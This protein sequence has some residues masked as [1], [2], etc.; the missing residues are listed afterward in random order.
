MT[1]N[2][3]PLRIGIAGYGPGVARGARAL[4]LLG[5]TLVGVADRPWSE[6]PEAE[7]GVLKTAAA[8]A[9]QPYPSV[10]ALLSDVDVLVVASTLSLRRRH[11]MAAFDRGIP[12][13]CEAPSAA[14][15][16]DAF[17]MARQA[18]MSYL[19]GATCLPA[20]RLP[21]V[22]AMRE[23]TA[24]G[25]LGRVLF[26]EARL[27]RRD[28]A[29]EQEQR[30]A[31]I[32]RDED[33]RLPTSAEF[34]S[35]LDLVETATGERIVTVAAQLTADPTGTASHRG[36]VCLVSLER[37]GGGYAAVSLGGRPAEDS[38]TLKVTCEHGWVGARSPDRF[39]F[40]LEPDVLHSTAAAV[41]PAVN[42][43]VTWDD[44]LGTA[45]LFA[46]VLADIRA[47]GP[48]SAPTYPTLAAGHRSTRL[49]SAVADSADHCA[50]VPVR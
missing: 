36:D 40:D 4:E 35:L 15:P 17:M 50:T 5:E 23:W 25:I 48:A 1:N 34:A 44:A 31:G 33:L 12:V 26:A 21:S 18:E 9:T 20:R 22:V 38:V 2:Q 29:P 42:P 16:L 41:L 10:D 8:H 37:G 47:G 39:E 6:T 3:P 11:V 32:P 49:I 27:A 30:A 24:A 46:D 14:D 28:A 19:V 13:I 7:H 43:L 45:G